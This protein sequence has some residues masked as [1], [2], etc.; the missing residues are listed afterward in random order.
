M[1]KTRIPMPS[2]AHKRLRVL[3]IDDEPVVRESIAAY[4]ED[5]GFDVIQAGN[6]QEGLQRL[7]ADAGRSADDIHYYLFSESPEIL[8]THTEKAR[9]TFGTKYFVPNLLIPGFHGDELVFVVLAGDQAK[10]A[11]L[12]LQPTLF[13]PLL[14]VQE[15]VLHLLLV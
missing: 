11:P 8:P 6:G 4:L 2:S 7:R 13:S 15:E 10:T 5:S 1:R 3:A 12:E 9:A 14:A